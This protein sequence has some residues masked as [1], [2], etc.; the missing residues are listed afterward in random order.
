MRIAV[1]FEAPEELAQR[2]EARIATL[3]CVR[4]ARLVGP[5]ALGHPVEAAA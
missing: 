5:R 1:H 2:L 4:E 3:V